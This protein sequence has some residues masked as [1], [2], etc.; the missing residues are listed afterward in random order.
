[1]AALA[2]LLA[3]NLRSRRPCLERGVVPQKLLEHL[4]D[5]ERSTRMFTAI[6][7]LVHS[8]PRHVHCGPGSL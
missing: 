3:H 8:L 5:A 6:L 4:F 1:M 2:Q 7:G